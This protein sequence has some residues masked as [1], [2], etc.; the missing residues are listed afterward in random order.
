MQ[1]RDINNLLRPYGISFECE[2]CDDIQAPLRPFGNRTNLK[3]KK[4][5]KKSIKNIPR[6]QIYEKKSASR[7]KCQTA[8]K[9]AKS[10]LNFFDN[11]LICRSAQVSRNSV[12][13]PPKNVDFFSEFKQSC[14]NF[15]NCPQF[16]NPNTY[17]ELKNPDFDYETTVPSLQ[18][19]EGLSNLG[20]L[21]LKGLKKDLFNESG[22]ETNYGE[23]APE[24]NFSVSCDK[25]EN[26]ELDFN[27][28]FIF[29]EFFSFA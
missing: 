17:D 8:K 20:H 27:Q 15:L 14:D 3:N 26:F 12:Y 23:L 1:L 11:S 19:S 2:S 16:E 13:I 28:D 7:T 22:V 9:Q 24:N 10:A 6:I 29:S 4:I 25:N 21:I 18:P 5:Q